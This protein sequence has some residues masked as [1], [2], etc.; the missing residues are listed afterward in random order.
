MWQGSVSLE[1][2]YK[3]SVIKVSAVKVVHYIMMQ[4]YVFIY[5][6]RQCVH[7]GTSDRKVFY[8]DM[9]DAWTHHIVNTYIIQLWYMYI[10]VYYEESWSQG[11]HF[12]N[13]HAT[14]CTFHLHYTRELSCGQCC[15]CGLDHYGSWPFNSQD[16]QLYYVLK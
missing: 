1:C 6:M 7:A 2:H 10:H 8:F 14:I 15:S 12:D 5:T 16:M 9:L 13:D 4:H 11:G 3:V